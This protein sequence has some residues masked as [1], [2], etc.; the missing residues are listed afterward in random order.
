MDE[1]EEKT[2]CKNKTYKTLFSIQGN[3]FLKK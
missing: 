3:P 2:S 1:S